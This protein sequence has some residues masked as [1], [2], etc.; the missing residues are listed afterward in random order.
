MHDVLRIGGQYSATDMKGAVEVKFLVQRLLWFCI[1]TPRDWFKKSRHFVIQSSKTKTNSFARV[2]PR[3]VQT[4]C[5]YL[6]G[7][8]DCLRLL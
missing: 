4:K 7:L 3:F 8:L 5:V 2:F 6:V 1:T